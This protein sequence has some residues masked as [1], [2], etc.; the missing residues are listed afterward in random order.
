M[1]KLS[2]VLDLN[3]IYNFIFEIGIHHQ[4]QMKKEKKKKLKSSLASK[5]KLFEKWMKQTKLSKHLC[6]RDEDT[7]L[8]NMWLKYSGIKV[9]NGKLIHLMNG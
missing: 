3:E 7:F 4:N 9:I 5:S 8:W 2:C 6:K 1:G